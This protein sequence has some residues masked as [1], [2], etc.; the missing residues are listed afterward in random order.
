M[1]LVVLPPLGGKGISIETLVI[2]NTGWGRGVGEKT[3]KRCPREYRSVCIGTNPALC[4][5]YRPRRIQG[6]VHSLLFETWYHF[7]C[8]HTVYAKQRD[9]LSSLYRYFPTLLRAKFLLLAIENESF[10]S[11]ASKRY[12][13]EIYQMFSFFSEWNNDTRQ[14][15]STNFEKHTIILVRWISIVSITNVSSR[16]CKQDYFINLIGHWPSTASTVRFQSDRRQSKRSTIVLGSPLTL[17]FVCSTMLNI[18]F[19]SKF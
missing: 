9:D 18:N 7:T 1:G 6:L 15:I 11:S 12:T 5:E 8:K 16:Y 19:K 4:L 17:D 14:S 13:S 3:S 10:L 2:N